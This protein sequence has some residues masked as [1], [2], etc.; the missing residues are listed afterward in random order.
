M[1][2]R[3][4]AIGSKHRHSPF[5]LQVTVHPRGVFFDQLDGTGKPRI[6]IHTTERKA[7]RLA[8]WILDNTEEE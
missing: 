6:V 4:A 1:A 8:Q 3:K 2:A 5:R 7:R